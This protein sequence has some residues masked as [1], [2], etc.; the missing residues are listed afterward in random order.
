MPAM[1]LLTSEAML[2]ALHL[3]RY[4]VLPSLPL[5]DLK[6][7]LG[8]VLRKLPAVLQSSLKV[9]ASEYLNALWK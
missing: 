1:L 2:T 8:A 3:S 9:S 6:G 5:H 4:C 7:Y